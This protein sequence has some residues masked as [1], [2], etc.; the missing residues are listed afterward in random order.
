MLWEHVFTV[1]S[2]HTY[3]TLMFIP[4]VERIISEK[5]DLFMLMW[6]GKHNYTINMF[7]DECENCSIIAMVPREMDDW[8]RHALL[9]RTGVIICGKDPRVGRRARF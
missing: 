5:S 2:N 6:L 7:H 4:G 8:V 3:P 9:R 1:C